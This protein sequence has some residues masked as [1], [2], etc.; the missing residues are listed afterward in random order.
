MDDLILAGALSIIGLYAAAVLA[1]AAVIFTF[2][3]LYGATIAGDSGRVVIILA[4]VF[5]IVAAYTG[6]GRWLQK[7]GRI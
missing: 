3:E 6:T 7:T 1:V 2:L 5:L 4:I